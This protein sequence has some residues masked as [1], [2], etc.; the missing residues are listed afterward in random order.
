[1]K[2]SAMQIFKDQRVYVQLSDD[3]AYENTLAGTLIDVSEDFITL[4]NVEALRSSIKTETMI[5]SGKYIVWVS[6]S[7]LTPQANPK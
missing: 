3:A 6:N 2:L 5:L 7:S 4:K 1:M